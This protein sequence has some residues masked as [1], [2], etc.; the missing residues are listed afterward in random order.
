MSP[1]IADAFYFLAFL[2]PKDAAHQRAIDFAKN[3]DSPLITSSWVLTEVADGIAESPQRRLFRALLQELEDSPDD[4][5]V[6]W[7]TTLFH[8]AVVLYESRPDKGWSLTDCTSFV[9]MREQG[10]AE[11]LTGDHHFEQAGFAALLR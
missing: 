5:I 1:V 3:C 4:N 9:I 10:I 7:D 11:A 8:R 2:N 6:W